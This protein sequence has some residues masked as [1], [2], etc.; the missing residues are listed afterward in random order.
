MIILLINNHCDISIR[1]K[2]DHLVVLLSETAKAADT[3]SIFVYI[4]ID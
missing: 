3:R 2:D 4:Y 1:N